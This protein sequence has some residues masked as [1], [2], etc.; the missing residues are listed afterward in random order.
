MFNF[1]DLQKNSP[2]HSVVIAYRGSGCDP[3]FLPCGFLPL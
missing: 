2:L 1:K 3:S